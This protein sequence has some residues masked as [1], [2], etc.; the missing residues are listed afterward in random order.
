MKE[1]S[2]PH[3]SPIKFAQKILFKEDTNARISLSFDELPSLGMMLEAAAQSSAAF[4]DTTKSGGFLVSLKNI[5]LLKKPTKLALE[6]SL[7]NEHNLQDM[8]YFSF[9]IYEGSEELVSG[10]FVIVKNT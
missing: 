8:S 7:S 5:K 3:I 1:L 6:V 2:L 10:S 4:G 9:F